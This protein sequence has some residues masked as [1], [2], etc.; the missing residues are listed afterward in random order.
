[1]E[2]ALGTV[3]C[4]ECL[5]LVF[6][7]R[8]GRPGLGSGESLWGQSMGYRRGTASWGQSLVPIH[9]AFRGRPGLDSEESL[10]ID[11]WKEPLE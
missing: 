11:P 4:N 1:M 5:G 7:A 2:H 10:E 3:P 8:G 9:E 6:G